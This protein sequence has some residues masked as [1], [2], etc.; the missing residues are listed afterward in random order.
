M[1]ILVAVPTFETIAPETF[2]SIWDLDKG[3]HQVDFNYI[4]GYDCAR[5]RNDIAE[6]AQQN[7]YDYVLM[8][9]SDVIIPSDALIKM[10]EFPCDIVLGCCPRKNARDKRVE[11]YKT[12]T[13]S[14]TDY[15]TYDTLPSMPRITIKGGG[16][17]CALVK[18]DCFNWI[19]FPWFKYV[20]YDDDSTL[21]EDLYFC[22]NAVKAGMFIEADTRVRCGH[23]ARYYQYE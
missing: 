20:T 9:D 13:F 7:E 14:F 23:L 1:K 4:K 3:G 2:K 22:L 6:M 11:L 17:A 15:Y 16:F 19:E 12:G 18:V 5:A 10:L 8:V 21:S